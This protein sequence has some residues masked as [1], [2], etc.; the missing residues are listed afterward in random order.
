MQGAG[1][2]ERQQRIISRVARVDDAA[3]LARIERMLEE[4]LAQ[5]RLV[6]LREDDIDAILQNL[7]E[8][9]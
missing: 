9:D 6:P 2:A 1:L 4:H 5:A 7:L 8:C 3:L